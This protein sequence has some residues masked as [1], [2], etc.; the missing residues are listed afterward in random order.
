[1]L[2]VFWQLNIM[3]GVCKVLELAGGGGVIDGATLSSSN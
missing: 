3:G 1:M 2:E